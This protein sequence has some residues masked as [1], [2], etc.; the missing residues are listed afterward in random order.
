[1]DQLELQGQKNQ[2]E[3]N[4]SDALTSYLKLINLCRINQNVSLMYKYQVKAAEIQIHVNQYD[5]A[6][7]HYQEAINI[8]RDHNLL[9]WKMRK[10][11][12][13]T[14]LCHLANNDRDQAKRLIETLLLE[15]TP[16][17]TILLNQDR[18]ELNLDPIYSATG[19][20]K[21]IIESREFILAKNL[22]NVSSVDQL[23][24]VVKGYD[25]ISH[26]DSFETKLLIQFKQH[27]LSE[28]NY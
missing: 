8:A 2:Q 20:L 25:S 18:T 28:P 11:V 22:T 15:E 16:L 10:L 17:S 7:Y 26:L 19:S 14:V 12:L 21:Y 6:A 4:Y 5:Q 24:E 27:L 9:K 1:M 23:L 13:M 3:G